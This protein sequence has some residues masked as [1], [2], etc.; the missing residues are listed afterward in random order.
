M[1]EEGLKGKFVLVS[2]NAM[3]FNDELVEFPVKWQGTILALRIPQNIENFS[4]ANY[5]G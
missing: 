5:L 4:Y 1:I 2:G 3:L